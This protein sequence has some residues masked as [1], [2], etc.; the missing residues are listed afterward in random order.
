MNTFLNIYS[1]LYWITRLDSLRTFAIAI[2]A[3]FT[4]TI[5]VYFISQAVENN[6]YKD[7]TCKWFYRLCLA[8]L[9]IFAPATILLPTERE[10][11]LILAGGKTIEFAQQDT[12]LQK[13]P[14]QTTAIVSKFLEEQLKEVDK[15]QEDNE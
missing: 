3:I 5:L 14:A 1:D 13:I 8:I 11:F 7:F 9:I 2:T 15:K 12:S 10:T 4:F 6:S